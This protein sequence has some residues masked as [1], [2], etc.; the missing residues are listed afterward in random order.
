MQRSILIFSFGLLAIGCPLLAV[1]QTGN[2][3]SIPNPIQGQNRT[4]LRLG[5]QGSEVTQIQGVLKLL[6]YYSGEVN[7]IYDRNTSVAVS[8]FQ[9]AAGLE[10][11]GIFGAATWN[12]LLPLSP[13]AVVVSTDPTPSPVVPS[14][15]PTE[16]STPETTP[17]TPTPTSV[18]FPVLR[19]GMRGEAIAHLQ[20]RLKTLGF[21][22]GEVDGVFGANT[23]AAVKAAQRK[24]NLEADGIVG[25]STWRALLSNSR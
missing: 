23:L 8:R 12:L 7:G 3:Q 24:Y 19:E 17:S 14:P 9:Q 18:T 1:A 5:S 20:Q 10:P 22:Q 16:S 13:E 25:R 2:F 21:L 11:D 15:S 6:G 4:I